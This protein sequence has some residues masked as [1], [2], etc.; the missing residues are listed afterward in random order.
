MSRTR[1][2]PSKLILAAL[3]A[4]TASGVAHGAEVASNVADQL[5]VAAEGG[6]RAL[7]DGLAGILAANPSLAAAPA[8][9]AALARSA[10]APVPDLVGSNLPVYREIAERIV[11]AAPPA[12]REAVRKAV[13][14]ELAALIDNDINAM[15]SLP[16]YGIGNVRREPPDAGQAGYRVGSFTIYPSV[17]TG[18]FYDDNIYATKTGRVSDGVGT[19]SPDVA[20]QSNWDRHS[21]YAEAGTDLTGYLSNG[22]ENTIDWHARTEGQIDVSDNTSILLGTL[23]R[24]EHEDRSSPDAVEGI[25]PTPYTDLNAYSGVV[26]RIGDFTVRFGGA[27]E[28]TT[29]GNVEGLHGTINNLDRDHNRYT[30]GGLVRDDANTGFRPF[31]EALGDFRRYDQTVDDFGYQRNSAGYRA[32]VG[33][34]FRLLPSVSGSASVG[35]LARTYDDPRF[36]PITT[37]AVT[38]D[39]RWQASASTALVLFIDRSIEETTLPGSPAY[40]YTVGGG[41]IEQ[42]LTDDL[43]GYFRLAAAHSDFVQVAQDNEADVSVGVRYRLTNRVFL[44]LDYRYTQRN[45]ANSYFNYNR[46]ETFLSLSSDL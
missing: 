33:A 22:S 18:V 9:A 21:L 16:P 4:S 46:N 6:P 8:S 34:L 17:Q 20:I 41:R 35:V 43:T 40:I 25:T 27:A 1:S 19:V 31:V 10:A 37:P 32:G 44:G 30:I 15:P 5:T 23:A 7:L 28:R 29:F 39:L 11:A 2:W 36:K 45:S 12:Q 24:Q 42:T 14:Q 38:A 13:G 3:V 26:H